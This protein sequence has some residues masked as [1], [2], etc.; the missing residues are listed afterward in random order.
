MTRKLVAL[1]AVA[2][3]AGC[4][5]PAAVPPLTQPSLRVHLA[6]VNNIPP[7]LQWNANFG[8]CGETSL[9]SAGLYYGQYASQYT[10]RSI[11]S[12]GAPQYLQRSQ[13]L[14]GVNDVRAA[15][16]MHL[17][18]I[19]FD[20]AK[21]SSTAQ[22][23]T[24]VR[25][26]VT[27]GRPVAIGVYTNEFRFY[28]KTNPKAGDPQY[29]HIVPVI[30]VSASTLTFSDNGLWSPSW[31]PRY[32]FT[33]DFNSFPK[34][35]AQA[36]RQG[37]AIY[38]LDG[39][40]TNFGIAIAG[41][42]DPQRETLPVRVAT[43]VNYERPAMVN[44]STARPRPMPLILT[45]VVSGLRPGVAYELYRYNRFDA[46]PDA[47][48]NANAKRAF[49]RWNISIRSGSIYVLTERIMSDQI[50]AYRAVPAAAP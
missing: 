16:R 41:V 20:T 24:W 14:L 30:G 32:E 40:G 5:N 23:L 18:S 3:L 17:N 15:T 33:Y 10:V 13:L 50:A 25:S 46:I 47:R 37:G 34:T 21:E 45:V 4:T 27:L 29:D 48:F 35:R 38:S 22:F 44:G 8:Y 1:L 19:E 12:N 9:I 49:E 7:R 28:G 26:N 39:G 6:A 2:A 11:A 42:T 31:P 36:N 43:D